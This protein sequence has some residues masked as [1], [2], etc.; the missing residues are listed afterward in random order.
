MNTNTNKTF[1]INSKTSGSGTIHSLA[2]EGFDREIVFHHGARFAVVISSFYGGNGYS[3]HRTE[4][5]AAKAS[6]E[7]QESHEI[8]DAEGRI[9]DVVNFDQLELRFGQ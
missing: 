2:A 9:Y 4:E 5:A 6:R 3:T 8:I 7:T 1:T